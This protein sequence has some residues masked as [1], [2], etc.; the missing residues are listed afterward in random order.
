VGHF[1]LK[2]AHF[3]QKRT[4]KAKN[5]RLKGLNCHPPRQNRQIRR[6]GGSHHK[7][8]GEMKADGFE[9]L[10]KSGGR[11]PQLARKVGRVTPCAPS[12]WIRTG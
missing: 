10:L 3:P 9:I 6:L 1:S 2:N 8:T 4:E 11:M 5:S 7:P 12:W